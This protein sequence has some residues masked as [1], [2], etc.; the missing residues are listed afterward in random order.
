MY[1]EKVKGYPFVEVAWF[2][3]GQKIQDKIA[4][5]ITNHVQ[6]QGDESLD[7]MFTIFEKH[8]YYDNV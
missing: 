5:V 4:N 2:D 7:I 6:E 1:G 3:R 8:R